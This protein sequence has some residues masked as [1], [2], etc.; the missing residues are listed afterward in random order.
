MRTTSG[1]VPRRAWVGWLV[2]DRFPMG[3]VRL[4]AF[5]FSARC[6]GTP[7][8]GGA[9]QRPQSSEYQ[10]PEPS[11]KQRI[12]AVTRALLVVTNSLVFPPPPGLGVRATFE[13]EATGPIESWGVKYPGSAHLAYPPAVYRRGLGSGDALDSTVGCGACLVGTDAE[14]RLSYDHYLSRALAGVPDPVRLFAHTPADVGAQVVF[15]PFEAFIGGCLSGI[16][17]IEYL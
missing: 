4:L 17:R 7:R 6:G 5:G 8:I 16:V 10:V 12:F 14:A 3:I 13:V 1:L 15:I 2:S 9:V 11:R